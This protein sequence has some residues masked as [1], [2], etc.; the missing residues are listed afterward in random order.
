MWSNALLILAL[1]FSGC[2]ETKKTDKYYDGEALI[3]QKCA[4]CHNLDMPPK[5]SNDEKA[6]PMYTVTVHLRDWMKGGTSSEK[7]ANF[8][9]FV[10]SYVLSP[11][12]ENSYCVKEVLQ[13]YGLMPSQ[14]GKVTKEELGAIAEYALRN[15]EQQKLL[16]IMKEQNRIAA[17]KPYEQVLALKDCKLCHING[18]GKVGPLFSQIAAKYTSK[19]TKKIKDAIVNGSKGRWPNYHVPMRAYKDLTPKQLDGIAKWILSQEK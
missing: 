7:E 10:Q 19:D 6:P 2:G 8:V 11:S 13:K 14:K 4:S 17:M 15:Y 12:K 5:I 18:N 16:E 3:K 9:A 1:A